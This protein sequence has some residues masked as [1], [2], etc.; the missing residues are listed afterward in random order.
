MSNTHW[1]HNPTVIQLRFK[2]R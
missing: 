1:I 2:T